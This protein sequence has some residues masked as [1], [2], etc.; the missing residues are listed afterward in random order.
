MQPRPALA[1]RDEALPVRDRQLDRRQRA[2]GQDRAGDDDAAGRLLLDHQIGA[3]AS[4]ADCSTMREHLGDRARPPA[5]SEAALLA[6][7]CTW[8]WLRAQRAPMRAG[9]AHGVQHLGVAPAGLRQAVA[10]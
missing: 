4:T 3:D 6:G 8:H 9:H 1:R 7:R 5:T 10:R 2:R